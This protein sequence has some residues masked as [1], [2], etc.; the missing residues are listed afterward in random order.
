MLFIASI[1]LQLFAYFKQV[2]V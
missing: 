2:R 1:K